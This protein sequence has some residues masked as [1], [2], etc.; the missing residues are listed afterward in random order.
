MSTRI[1]TAPARAGTEAER[2]PEATPASMTA[3]MTPARSTEPPGRTRTT[4]PVSTTSPA[5]A[6]TRRGT[7]PSP[8]STRP[9]TRATCWPETAVRW[10]I[11]TARISSRTV[12]GRAWSS[13]RATPGTRARAPGGQRGADGPAGAPS[14]SAGSAARPSPAGSAPAACSATS[15]GS[16]P[17]ARARPSRRRPTR[18]S[19]PDGSASTLTEAPAPSRAASAEPGWAARSG[20]CTRT[21]APRGR[22]SHRESPRTTAL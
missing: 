5:I 12:R 10:V 6:R 2:R 11:E 15:A 1:S 14:T 19:E 7:A 8:V 20:P 4:R 16:A 17:A 13:P 9:R 22:S 3:P 18:A 21:V